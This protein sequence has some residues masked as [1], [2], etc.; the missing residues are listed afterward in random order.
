MIIIKENIGIKRVMIG[1]L[2]SG[3]K[4]NRA[5]TV[6]LALLAIHCLVNS[7]RLCE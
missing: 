7:A 1:G 3:Q 4:S 2:V 6:I 5:K